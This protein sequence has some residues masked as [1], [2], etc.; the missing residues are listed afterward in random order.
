M[1]TKHSSAVQ[2]SIWHLHI[3]TSECLRIARERSKWSRERERKRPKKEE[4]NKF[5]NT[6]KARYKWGA[7]FN[8]TDRAERWRNEMNETYLCSARAQN[9]TES[10][11][12]NKQISC[13]ERTNSKSTVSINITLMFYSV[14]N[15]FIGR[16]ISCPLLMQPCLSFSLFL[17]FFSLFLSLSSVDY[18]LLFVAFLGFVFARFF[19]FVQE[20][21]KK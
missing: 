8:W 3:R 18:V 6:K 10:Q 15:P 2:K 19:V 12:D 1:H 20:K 17:S 11:R 9:A 16:S 13:T 4:H 21:R 7:H 5:K 14:Q